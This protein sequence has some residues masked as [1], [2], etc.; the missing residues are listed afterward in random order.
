MAPPAPPLADAHGSN[1]RYWYFLG[2]LGTNMIRLS[3]CPHC[4]KSKTTVSFEF[5]QLNYGNRRM[6]KNY[7]LLRL[8]QILF[9]DFRI[10]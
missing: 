2:T 6:I 10:S 3:F 7:K 1:P 5:L 4:L 8:I 9:V